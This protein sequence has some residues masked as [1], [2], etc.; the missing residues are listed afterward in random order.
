MSESAGDNFELLVQ[1]VLCYLE[2]ER[3]HSL[4]VISNPAPVLSPGRK[5]ALRLILNPDFDGGDELGA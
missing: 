2:G 3:A 5:P 4:R 1:R